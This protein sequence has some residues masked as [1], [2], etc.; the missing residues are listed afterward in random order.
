MK[1]KIKSIFFLWLIYLPLFGFPQNCNKLP[2]KF[3]TYKDAENRIT[4]A[5]FNFTDNINTSTS[6]FVTSANFYSC[7]SKI[8]YLIIGLK[9]RLYIHQKV[10]TELWINFKKASSFGSFY[11][12]YIRNKY[13]LHLTK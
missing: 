8:G 1:S 2:K 3:S 13:P 9:G 12:N 11:I 7:D 6:S 5:K 4:S 10:P